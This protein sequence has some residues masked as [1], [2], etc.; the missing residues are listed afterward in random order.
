[1]IQVNIRT[2][3]RN[4]ADTH[5]TATH[6]EGDALLVT[7]N[8]A[9]PE[10]LTFAGQQM[11]RFDLGARIPRDYPTRWVLTPAAHIVR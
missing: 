4:W 1:M 9:N 2:T 10:H 6:D 11:V 3:D 8:A 5:G 7:V